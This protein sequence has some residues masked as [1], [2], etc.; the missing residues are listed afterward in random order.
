[1]DL[2][3]FA[4][5]SRVL[6]GSDTRR[7]LLTTL[8]LLGGLLALA[9]VEDTL[10][11]ERRHRRKRRHKRRKNPGNRKHGC[12]PKGKGTICAGTCGPIKSRQTCG[13]TID[14]GSCDCPTP[15]GACFICQSGP[16]TT[17]TC[18][19]DPA[20][21][22]EPCGNAGQFCQDDGICACSADT[23]ANPTPLCMGGTCVPCTDSAQCPDCQACVGGACLADAA[24]QHTCAGPCPSGEWCDAGACASIQ[25]TVTILDCQSLCDGQLDI[26]GESITCPTC[27]DCDQE[28]GC[29]VN[30][31]AA[32]PAGAGF[33]CSLSN[34]SYGCSTDAD[35]ASATPYDDCNSHGFCTRICPFTE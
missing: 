33:Y 14:C 11:R 15:C 25:A 18:V 35:C 34:G 24:L 9:G 19:P 16:N 29:G 2:H 32:G 27:D 21:V 13:K 28:T 7:R 23:C 8:P 5:L 30:L 26:C 31:L 10:A 20:Q 6:S 22:G 1:M 12:R 3:R 17:G 4:A